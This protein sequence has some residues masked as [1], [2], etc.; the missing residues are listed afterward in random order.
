[1]RILLVNKFWY[2]RGGDC[3]VAMNTADLLRRMGH[4]AG[5]FTMDYPQNIDDPHIAGR[6]DEVGFAGPLTTQMRYLRRAMG[7]ADVRQPFA[8]TLREFQPDVV[9]LHNIHS[10]ISP[11]V[12]QIAHE[13][14]CRVV[15]TMHDYKL[16]CPTYSCL[17]NGL[18]CTECVEHPLE[19]VNHRCMK[20]SFT[21][22]VAALMEATHW[23]RER[24]QQWVDKFICPSGFM[25][26]ML[27]KGD[28]P[29]DKTAVI[30]NFISAKRIPNSP[31]P[32][33]R[34]DYCCYVGRLSQEK[35]VGTLLEAAS[36]LP[37]TLKVAGDGPLLKELQQ[38][39]GQHPNIQLLGRLD[40]QQVDQLLRLARFSV[41]PS[42][43]WENCP[44]SII[45]SLC[46]GTPVVGTRTGG[47]PELLDDASSLLVGAGDANA[48]AETMQQAWD[49]R[50]DHAAIARQAHVRFNEQTY[51]RQLLQT[52]N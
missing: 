21:A 49:R 36:Q 24:L 11:A 25:A 1:M 28:I 10:Y 18:P 13:Q 46:A 45:E 14:G 47:I 51:Y 26:Q 42:E 7:W 33:G 39:Y 3:I 30:H 27:Q 5:V 4:E 44:L 15:W 35:G 34:A 40:A 9:H 23:N 20:H 12:A 38:R 8:L 32:T 22:S 43:C 16:L 6:A 41:M 52:Y 37:F 19:V 29:A 50:W 17:R 31:I 48:L 2:P